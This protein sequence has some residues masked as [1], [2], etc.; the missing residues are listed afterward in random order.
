MTRGPAG[1]PGR[2]HGPRAS[3]NVRAH[4][5]P[6]WFY[7]P[8]G[9]VYGLI[10]LVPT[11]ISFYFAFTRWT[12]F[13][14]EFIGLDNFRQFFSE[15]ALR[16]RPQEHARLRRRHQRSQGGARH[17]PRGAAHRPDPRHGAC[18]ARSSSSRCSSARSPSASPSACCSSPTSGVVSTV[19]AKVGITAP[20]WLGDPPRPCSRSPSST[21]G[22]AS[23]SPR[24]STSP[25]SSPSPRTTT[26]RSTSTAAEPGPSSGTSPFPCRGRRP[27]RSSCSP[28][29]AA[30]GPST[31]SG[32]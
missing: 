17:A 9:I 5:Y 16:Q 29:S 6:Y 4:T 1:P 14:S 15:Q 10:F 19:L 21:S 25:G 12:L 3:A 24:S 8:A 2:A 27:S 11:V 23:G 26:R 32:P 31:S 7:A 20:D 13:E 28:S 30:S 18:C 22:R